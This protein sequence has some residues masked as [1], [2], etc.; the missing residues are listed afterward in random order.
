LLSGCAA[1]PDACAALGL[2]RP[3]P[4]F[5]ARWTRAEKEQVAAHNLTVEKICPKQE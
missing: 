1:N 2:I 5:Q 4:G 3:D